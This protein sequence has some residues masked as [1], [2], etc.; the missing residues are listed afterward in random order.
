MFD[1]ESVKR[2]VTFRVYSSL[3]SGEQ[4]TRPRGRTAAAAAAAG[5][6]V[7]FTFPEAE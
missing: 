4:R 2:S 7:S 6:Q 5:N 1:L 3:M